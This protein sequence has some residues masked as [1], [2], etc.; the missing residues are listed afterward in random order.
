MA[1]AAREYYYEEFRGESAYRT[2]PLNVAELRYGRDSYTAYERSVS[3]APH[4]YTAAYASSS[5]AAW[6]AQAPSRPVIRPARPVPVPDAPPGKHRR[7]RA[8]TPARRFHYPYISAKE[9]AFILSTVIVLGVTFMF[10]ILLSSYQA[11]MQNEVNST[12]AAAASVQ[13]DID[14]IRVAIEKSNTIGVIEDNAINQLGMSYPQASQIVYLDD[15]D[16]AANE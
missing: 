12:K 14:E 16:G 2:P 7:R 11:Y 6:P 3:R 9:K 5:A 8:E 15:A 13:K 4:S 10:I 1:M